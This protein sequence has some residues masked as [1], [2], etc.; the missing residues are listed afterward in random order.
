M[1]GDLRLDWR[2]RARKYRGLIAAALS[3]AGMA[4]LMPVVDVITTGS[5]PDQAPPVIDTAVIDTW[6][7]LCAGQLLVKDERIRTLERERTQLTAALTQPRG[8]NEGS[9]DRAARV[10]LASQVTSLQRELDDMRAARDALLADNQ[11]L[12][13]QNAECTVFPPTCLDSVLDDGLRTYLRNN[14]RQLCVS[15]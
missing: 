7:E 15:Q 14:H 5:D 1:E 12:E 10:A 9:S 13:S 11:A 3:A 6:R 4:A 2:G 8:A